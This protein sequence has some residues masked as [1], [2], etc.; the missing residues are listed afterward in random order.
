MSNCNNAQYINILI[1]FEICICYKKYNTFLWGAK[2][3]L[4]SITV[5]QL[6]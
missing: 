3:L 4:V 2:E 5:S 6:N 1:E